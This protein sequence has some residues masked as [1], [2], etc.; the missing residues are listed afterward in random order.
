VHVKRLYIQ[1]T[2]VCVWFWAFQPICAGVPN[3]IRRVK[4]AWS[5]FIRHRTTDGYFYLLLPSPDT[6]EED[7]QMETSLCFSTL[8]LLLIGA[9]FTFQSQVQTSFFS[10]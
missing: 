3:P 5:I 9:I 8:L 2:C 6:T 7:E 4:D 1:Y 10:K